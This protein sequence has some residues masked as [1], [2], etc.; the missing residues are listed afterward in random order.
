MMKYNSY[1]QGSLFY[2]IKYPLIKRQI[3]WDKMKESSLIVT[4]SLMGKK[5]VE[6]SD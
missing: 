4:V 1:N 2:D 3:F 5:S 6:N